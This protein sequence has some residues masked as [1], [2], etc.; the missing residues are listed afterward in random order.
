M[1]SLSQHCRKLTYLPSFRTKRQTTCNFVSFPH[2]LSFL[3]ITRHRYLVQLRP[4][5]IVIL[6]V[7]KCRRSTTITRSSSR[8]SAIWHRWEQFFF[9][10]NLKNN[11][12]LMKV[13]QPAEPRF[14][15]AIS[16]NRLAPQVNHFDLKPTLNSTQISFVAPT[17]AS[18]NTRVD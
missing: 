10:N 13:Q 18:R 7:Y 2:L 9:K 15:Q 11:L 17:S 5:W 8:I 12:L 3:Q 4:I 16:V 6:D 1:C 14:P